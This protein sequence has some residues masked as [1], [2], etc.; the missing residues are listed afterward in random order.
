MDRHKSLRLRES[1]GRMVGDKVRHSLPLHY[2]KEEGYY[3]V[4]GV[5]SRGKGEIHSSIQ[6][7]RSTGELLTPIYHQSFDD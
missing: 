1:S 6:G 2:E 4:L 5:S 3:G 7:C